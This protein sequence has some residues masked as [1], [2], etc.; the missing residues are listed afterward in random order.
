[1]DIMYAFTIW[2]VTGLGVTM[3]MFLVAMCVIVIP[4]IITLMKNDVNDDDIKWVMKPLSKY[5]DEVDKM[6]TMELIANSVINVLLLWPINATYRTKDLIVAYHT[7]KA[8]KK[9][10]LSWYYK[11]K[12]STEN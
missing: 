5:A 4:T 3:I 2:M 1:M 11:G 6:P 12:V 7:I 9:V 10:A 8:R